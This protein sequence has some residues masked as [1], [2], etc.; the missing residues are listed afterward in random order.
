MSTSQ[1][2]AV[3]KRLEEDGLIVG[4]QVAVSDAPSRNKYA[5]TTEGDR[6]LNTWL[7]DS[8]PS[9]S[10]HRIRVIFLSKLYIAILL[11]LPFEDIIEHQKTACITQ[12][13]EFLNERKQTQ[14]QLEGLVLD[15]IISQLDSAL[16]WLEI[17]YDT[18]SPNQSRVSNVVLKCDDNTKSNI[19]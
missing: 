18:L 16:N 17:C 7:Y 8:N 1:L 15:F 2:Y 19:T 6:K 14:S 11:E 4:Q 13:N 9:S 12:R 5:I 10:I 3:L